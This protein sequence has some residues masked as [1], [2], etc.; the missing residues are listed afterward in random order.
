MCVC[1]WLVWFSVV[2]MFY[3]S[4]VFVDVHLVEIFVF[5]CVVWC[6][7]CVSVCVCCVCVCVFVFG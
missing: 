1:I 3:F 4:S 6:G 5:V 7:V 2:C